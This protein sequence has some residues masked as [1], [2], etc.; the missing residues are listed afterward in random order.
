MGQASSKLDEAKSIETLNKEQARKLY[1]EALD[2]ISEAKKYN[3]DKD[4]VAKLESDARAG[5]EG[6]L[7]LF[8]VTPSVFLDLSLVKEGFAGRNLA[9][10]NSRVIIWDSTSKS[11]VKLEIPTKSA[12]VVA[13]GD[14]LSGTK[15]ISL[16]EDSA[17]LVGS[18]GIWKVNLAK[19]DKA[20]IVQKDSELQEVFA[21]GAFL[22]NVYLADKKTGQIWK[23]TPVPSGYS[24]KIKYLKS[25]TNFGNAT[26]LTIDGSIWVLSSDGSILEFNQGNR[27]DFALSGLSENL[28]SKS[29]IFTEADAKNL[30]ILDLDKS[31]IF[32][33]DKTGKYL[34]QYKIDKVSAISDFVVSEKDKIA[35]LLSGKNLYS[36]ELK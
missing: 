30:Y 14:E 15:S 11:L 19:K 16:W 23:Y 32:V 17:F 36:F 13:G 2:K 4:K 25:D 27:V 7:E 10:Y 29:I 20:K 35:L 22:G 26:S 21:S 8:G 28:S 24:D 1:Q 12:E 31:T 9:F 34:S 33:F 3:L 18:D 6:S 5:Y